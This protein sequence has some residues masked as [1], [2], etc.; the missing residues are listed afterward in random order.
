MATHGAEGETPVERAELISVGT[1]LLLG[2]IVDTNSAYLASDLARRGVDVLWS[3]RVGDNRGRIEHLVAQGLSR[4]DLV[5]LCGGLGPT[6]DDLTRDAVAAVV[7]E[8]QYLDDGLVAWLRE[9]FAATGRTMPERNLQQARVIPSAEVLPNA[10]G[11]APGWLVRTHGGGRT[12]YVVTLPGP[13]RELTRMWEEQAVPRLPFPA[14]SIFTRTYKTNGLGESLVAERLGDLTQGANPSVATY[15]KRDG[16]H[17]RVAA[18]AAS[19]DAAE[20]LARPAMAAVER[21]LQGSVWGVDG[22]EM[23]SVVLRRLA[24]R[25]LTLAVAEGA[26]GG[27]LTE[28]LEEALDAQHRGGRLESGAPGGGEAVAAG[29]EERAGPGHG[30]LAGSVVAWRPET[31]RTLLP[32]LTALQRLP[33]GLHAGAAEV[34]AAVAAAVRALFAADVGIAI[35]YPYLAH[36]TAGQG[37]ASAG[38]ADVHAPP[39]EDE[40]EPGT[41]GGRRRPQLRLEIALSDGDRTTSQTLSLPPLGR[42]WARERSA[43]TGLNLLLRSVL[44]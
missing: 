3:A 23:A 43:F 26:S 29:D 2:E 9:H 5:V 22:D 16:V 32:H 18:K 11:T 36:A 28:L 14:A 30:A 10:I 15:A 31:M 44:R 42:G 21:A 19:A 20:E 6:D 24:E 4:S 34:V 1:E 41:V 39:S 7:G 17:V 35:G 12:R 25:G 13:P 40:I 33:A 38:A 27:L 8:E 37:G